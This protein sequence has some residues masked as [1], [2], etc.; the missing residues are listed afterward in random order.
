MENKKLLI[1]YCCMNC[2]NKISK[3]GA[4]RGL[5]R[6]LS[7]ANKGHNN[8]SFVNGKKGYIKNGYNCLEVCGN[9]VSYDGNRCKSCA[10]KIAG[11]LS[12]ETKK[13]MGAWVRVFTKDWR[14]N[15]SISLKKRFQDPKNH[16][17]FNKPMSKNTK[18]KISQ[19]LINNKSMVGKNNPNWID[20]RSWNK[21][22]KEFN[23]KLRLEVKTRDNHQCK[24]CSMT[25][26]EHI[27]KYN[28][29]LH[30]HH[31]DYNKQNC[32]KHNL[33]TT[34]LKCNVQANTNRDYWR[35]FYNNLIKEINLLEF[36]KSM[37][38]IQNGK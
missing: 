1:I 23:N 8:P 15:L 16:P 26:E 7:C 32:D 12:E 14:N 34:C 35:K 3:S 6:C 20:G 30:V 29:V 25:E 18:L 19:T 13:K 9:R 37:V 33:I 31:I 2:G 28:R 4:L 5:G 36:S 38:S 21:Y 27:K 24:H 11:P 22:P 17:L 10:R